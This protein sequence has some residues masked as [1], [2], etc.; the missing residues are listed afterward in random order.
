MRETNIELI[1]RL[2][3]NSN[4]GVLA[5]VFV[6]EA[7]SRYVDLVLADTSDWPENSF[8]SQAAWKGIAGDMREALSNRGK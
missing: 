6:I 5:E 7:I 8:V 2:M 3:T 1:N 4:Y